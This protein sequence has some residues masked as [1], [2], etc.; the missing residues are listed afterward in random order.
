[1]LASGFCPAHAGAD[2]A[3]LAQR[4]GQRSGE[5]RRQQRRS[6][7][8]RLDERLE[9]DSYAAHQAIR[10]ALER[11]ETERARSIIAAIAADHHEPIEVERQQRIHEREEAERAEAEP[12]RKTRADVEWELHLRQMQYE[13]DGHNPNGPVIDSLA[14]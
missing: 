7:A 1:V 8:A 11:D 12:A 9:A 10:S 3:E 4:G 6:L 14:Q 2:M 13:R 5:I